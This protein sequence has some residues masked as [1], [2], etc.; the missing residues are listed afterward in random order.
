MYK[1][2]GPQ[3]VENFKVEVKIEKDNWQS[4]LKIFLFAS[5]L[6][7]TTLVSLLWES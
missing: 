4:S 2:R 7:V 5:V 1:L 6:R 3:F